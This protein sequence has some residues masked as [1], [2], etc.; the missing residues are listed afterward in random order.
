MNCNKIASPRVSVLMPV[1]NGELYL[2]EAVD[3]ILNQTY[4]NFEFLIIDDGSTDSSAELIKSYD[5]HRIQLISLPCNNGLVNALNMGLDL[6]RGEYIARMDADDI[7][8]P[9]RFERQV[10]FMDANPDIVVGGSWLETFDGVKQKV[11]APPLTNEEIKSFLLFES[12]IYHPTVIMRKSIFSDSSVLYSSE[13]PHA[14]DYELWSRLS[15]SCRF[16]NIGKVLLKYRLHN[17]NV[18]SVYCTNKIDSA[19]RIRLKQLLYMGVNPCDDEMSIHKDI[20]LWRYSSD[21]VFIEKAL[22]WLCKLEYANNISNVYP[23]PVFAKVLA[24]R[25]FKICEVASI[26]GFVALHKFIN[27][28]LSSYS[29]YNLKKLCLLILK[30]AHGTVR[31]LWWS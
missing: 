23:E 30:C 28:P 3:S 6:A 10:H 14:E 12:V 1:Y 4:T 29:I 17:N 20:S 31:R 19:T 8:V 25:W 2:A 27:S 13:Y 9:E 22:E 18:S 21:R 7:S 26:K 15:R 16:A 11:W 5:D 24:E